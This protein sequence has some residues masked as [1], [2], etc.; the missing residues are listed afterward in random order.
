MNG[1][2]HHLFAVMEAE[3]ERYQA[4]LGQLGAH[5]APEDPAAPT[6]AAEERDE[7]VEKTKELFGAEHVKVMD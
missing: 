2:P 3:W 1:N 4:V 5:D 6:A 7:L